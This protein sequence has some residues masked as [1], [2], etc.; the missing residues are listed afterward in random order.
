M[1]LRSPNI[2]DEDAQVIKNVLQDVIICLEVERAEDFLVMKIQFLMNQVAEA[3][4]EKQKSSYS[5]NT[6]RNLYE[7]PTIRNGC[8][9]TRLAS[10]EDYGSS[11]N[12]GR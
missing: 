8:R 4:Y 11:T 6:I 2:P 10:L 12:D 3:Q 1:D 7:F 9:P 5:C